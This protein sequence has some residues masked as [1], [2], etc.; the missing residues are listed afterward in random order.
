M[1]LSMTWVQVILVPPIN[2]AFIL[3]ICGECK[4]AGSNTCYV[5]SND[6]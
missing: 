3:M 6:V 5:S 1:F 4:F 2:G